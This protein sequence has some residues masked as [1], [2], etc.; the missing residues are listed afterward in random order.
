MAILSYKPEDETPLPP[1]PAVASGSADESYEDEA[2]PKKSSCSK[3]TMCMMGILVICAIILGVTLSRPGALSAFG[4][5]AP[6]ASNNIGDGGT[7]TPTFYPTYYPTMYPTG[8]PTSEDETTTT[9]TTTVAATTTTVAALGGNGT[10]DGGDGNATTT[11][12]ATTTTTTTTTT[13]EKH[14][15]C[16]TPL[17]D[18]MKVLKVQATAYNI[19]A[20]FTLTY[21]NATALTRTAASGDMIVGQLYKEK[22]CVGPGEYKFYWSGDGEVEVFL[23]GKSTVKAESEL[24]TTLTVNGE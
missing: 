10:D 11:T 23:R 8:I 13:E 2:P 15:I 16:R 5:K 20:E 21:P 3:S 24:T 4:K 9:T 22:I 18:N 6:A 1:P 14:P 17:S 19:N 7:Y 12:A